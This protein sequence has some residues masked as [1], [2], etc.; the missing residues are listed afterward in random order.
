MPWKETCAM[1]ERDAFV[2]IY[3]RGDASM[4]ELC[5]DFGVSRK[6]GYKWL[7]RYQ[8]EGL[9]G[10]ADRRSTPL[11]CPTRLADEVVQRCVRL[12]RE[13][14]N[15]GPK[16]LIALGKKRQPTLYWP[17]ASTV[18]E[19]LKRLGL[20]KPRRRRNLSVPAYQGGFA[21]VTQANDV[22]F[23]DYKGQFRTGDGK[24]CYPL[25]VTDGH[26]R[27]ILCCSALPDV[28]GE[29]AMPVFEQLFHTYGLPQAIRTDNGPPFASIK[30]GFSRFTLWWIKLGI[31]HE[32]I[33]PGHPE[34]NG[35]HERMHRTLKAE[36]TRPPKHDLKTQQKRFDHWRD[37][38]NQERPHEALGQTT[39]AS[40]Y[41]KSDRSLPD[42]LAEREYPTHFEVRRVRQAGEIQWRNRRLYTSTVLVGERIGL[43]QIDA[44]RWQIWFGDLRVA[45]LDERLKKVLPMSPVSV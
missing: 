19:H 17:A 1:D 15:W 36:T 2:R 39:P 32:R 10:L 7:K 18:S 23:A 22:W 3:L 20:V 12:K 35:Q 13:K 44:D 41:V 37:E 45:V 34:Q 5:D 31:A 14:P 24:Y 8:H 4:T 21:E 40:R 26:S 29:N 28:S 33:E 27:F 16:K 6:T 25:T 30:M 42:C 9:A 43:Q 11:H 38:F